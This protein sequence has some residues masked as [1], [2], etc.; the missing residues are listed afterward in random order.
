MPLETPDWLLRLQQLAAQGLQQIQPQ[1]APP[2]GP[3]LE[4]AATSTQ[5]ARGMG[6]V[7]R[8]P[9][10]G[11]AVRSGQNVA[12]A[13]LPG[14]LPRQPQAAIGPRG[15]APSIRQN[16]E[17]PGTGRYAPT[18]PNIGDEG[19]QLQHIGRDALMGRGAF[20]PTKPAGMALDFMGV[21]GAARALAASA[22]STLDGHPGMGL[23]MASTALLPGGGLV[24]GAARD[25]ARVGA[26]ELG[27][28]E[29]IGLSERQLARGDQLVT[30]DARLADEAW[31]HDAGMY[32]APGG[33]GDNY[34]G[35][36]YDRARD[37]LGT[38]EGRVD[39]SEV[40][41]DAEGR[42]TFSDGRHRFAA[43]RDAG[44]TRVP[45][46][47]SAESAE[48]ARRAGLV[49]G[50]RA[51]AELALREGQGMVFQEAQSAGRFGFS[52]QLANLPAEQVRALTRVV[53]Q[54]LG[55]APE[56]IA[57]EVIG[58]RTGTPIPAPR[59]QRFEGHGVWQGARAPNDII[60]F[61]DDVPD[62]VI[63]AAAATRGLVE[64][65]DAAAWSRVV[66]PG[67]PNAEPGWVLT[68]PEGAPL[69]DGVLEALYT[70]MRGNPTYA[71]I[72]GQGLSELHGAALYR[73]F[74]GEVTHEQYEQLLAHAIETLPLDVDIQLNRRHFTGRYIDGPAAYL[75]TL[76]AD[77]D[78]L[79]S[80]RDLVGQVAPLYRL[81]GVRADDALRALGD[82]AR[83][84]VGSAPLA[85]AVR[86]GA[87][88]V[89]QRAGEL[90]DGLGALEDA[91]RNPPPRGG[92]GSTTVAAASPT[93]TQ[94]LRD[95]FAFAPLPAR[96]KPDVRV[97]VMADRA[98]QLM[99]DFAASTGMPAEMTRDWY[100]AAGKSQLAMARVIFPELRSDPKRILRTVAESILS[101]GQQ[102]N[103]E[104]RAGANVWE[105][106]TRDGIV[107]TMG[108]DAVHGGYTQATASGARPAKFFAGPRAVGI[109]GERVAGSS[110]QLTHET[111][112]QRLQA[113]V[114]TMGEERAVEWLFQPVTIKGASRGGVKAADRQVLNITELFGPKIGQYASDKLGIPSEGSTIDLWMARFYHML[115]GHDVPV[116]SKAA[117]LKALQ[118][119]ARAARKANDEDALERIAEELTEVKKSTES[120]FLDDKVT[121]QM[122]S[123]MQAVLGEVAKRNGATPSSAQAVA[124]YT[125]KN[126]FR[127]AGAREKPN[128]YATLSSAMGDF[129][130]GPTRAFDE[131]TA[132]GLPKQGSPI[133]DTYRAF[134]ESRVSLEAA[135][136][137][138]ARPGWG[139]DSA[140]DQTL[141]RGP[142]KALRPA[143]EQ[144]F[145][146]RAQAAEAKGMY[147]LLAQRV[148]ESYD[149]SAPKPPTVR[150]TKSTAKSPAK[151]AP[152]NRK[153]TP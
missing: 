127:Q 20:A 49:A 74:A 55:D 71:P 133:A 77:P 94:R 11:S 124:W 149:R 114:D 135:L 26:R 48:A 151:G 88:A 19:Y 54:E 60:A 31:R 123:E 140:L 5:L 59:I 84:G 143:F 117:K 30:L 56:R 45:V 21:P 107:S 119:E 137:T 93:I 122:R 27:A 92:T 9:A 24:R 7:G 1:P 67:T 87:R 153:A 66:A 53:H 85:G 65:Q 32:L 29:R 136:R 145:A 152:K 40:A 25:A 106:Y 80:A 16:D 36:R 44:A 72:T 115:T 8:M 15:A 129:L 22:E 81:F 17:G 37:F 86:T 100:R 4:Q 47:M 97:R 138:H 144:G 109:E 108:P 42:V 95:D 120:A 34:I 118:A 57:A 79:R 75:R 2:P 18:E 112:L 126:L 132:M 13:T 68:G 6:M 38:H 150:K 90:N 52:A 28:L 69:A 142:N 61:A 104:V 128:A 148:G 33:Q 82:A 64:G 70:H 83:G 141:K 73:N 99:D 89:D 147:E 96:A 110:R 139:M 130:T 125:V 12:R 43:L 63:D 78:A 3:S 103:D 58:R 76:G 35:Q 50:E 116:M 39:P 131:A 46:A 121:D 10:D 62:E 102:V 41:V 146:G 113:L 111:S 51:P 23:F 105:Q 14:A 134:P 98:Q 91:I 101:N